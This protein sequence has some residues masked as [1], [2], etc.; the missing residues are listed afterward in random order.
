VNFAD[1]ATTSGIKRLG[2]NEKGRVH[3]RPSTKAAAYAVRRRK[4]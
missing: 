1:F 3:P 2:G 4:D